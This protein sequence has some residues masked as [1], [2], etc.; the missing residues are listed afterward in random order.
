MRHYTFAVEPGAV[1]LAELFPMYAQHYREMQARLE[2]DGIPVGPFNM[3]LDVY[4]ERWIAG[5]LLNYVIRDEEAKAVGYA[6]VYLTNDMHNSEFIAQEDAIYVVPEHR[7][8][9]GKKFVRFILDDLRARG[10]KRVNITP[11]TDLRVS[12]IWARMG[13]RHAAEAMTFIF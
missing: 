2:K 6:N 1:T 7:N 10:V 4:I 12:K 3:R 8:G 5:S 11:V 9:V 13:F